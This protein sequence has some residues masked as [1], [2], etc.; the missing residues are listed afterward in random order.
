MSGPL[1]EL[2]VAAGAR[3]EARG[4]LAALADDRRQSHR[5][6]VEQRDAPAAVEDAHDRVL[7]DHAEVAPEG[8][9]EAASDGVARHAGDHRLAEPHARRAHGP[10][11]V[12]AVVLRWRRREGL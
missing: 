12:R 10:F 2:A 3:G 11:A 8:Q 5:A 4:A 6:A 1:V 7:L 9:L